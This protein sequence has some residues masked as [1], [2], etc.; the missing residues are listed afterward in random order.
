MFRAVMRGLL[1]ERSQ[2]SDD[3]I[4]LQDSGPREVI[5]D[6]D[7]VMPLAND[8]RLAINR[9]VPSRFIRH[10]PATASMPSFVRNDNAQLQ[11]GIVL[12]GKFG[13]GAPIIR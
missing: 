7:Q 1:R 9:A 3:T 8:L 12:V 2:Q 5:G 11:F 13:A 10:R 6:D 4:K